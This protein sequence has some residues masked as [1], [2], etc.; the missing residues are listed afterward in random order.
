MALAGTL[1]SNG[2]GY[3]GGESDRAAMLH[4]ESCKRAIE[5]VND[6]SLSPALSPGQVK[7]L[8]DAHLLAALRCAKDQ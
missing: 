2:F 1:A 4:V 8:V 6:E 7:M 5:T 3:F